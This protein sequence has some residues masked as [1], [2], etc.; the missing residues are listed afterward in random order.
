MWTYNQSPRTDELYHHGVLGQKWGVRRY[1]NADGSLT[2]QGRK[3][4]G[5]N[6]E[7]KE[8]AKRIAKIVGATAGS[9]A[10]TTAAVAGTVKGVKQLKGNDEVQEKMFKQGKD[11]KPSQA[12][13]ITKSADAVVNKSSDIADRIIKNNHPKV[14]QDTTQLS[15]EE[16]R[17]RVNRLNLER[18]YSDLMYDPNAMTKGE[19]TVKNILSIAGGVTAVA[20]S[21][22]TIATA[23]YTIKK[24]K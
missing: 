17:E 13:K 2:A 3:R 11:N 16:L 6:E 21:A 4:Y 7:R 23:I 24:G 9:V 12:E 15:D 1:Q 20:A 10:A 19:R 5:S 18:Q 14:K 22:A 8:K